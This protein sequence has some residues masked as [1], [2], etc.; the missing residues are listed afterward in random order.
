[1]KM[2]KLVVF[3]SVIVFAFS[4]LLGG[5]S[6]SDSVD[7]TKTQLYIGNF[8][9]GFGS[10]WLE[11]AKEYFEE[12]YK[13]VSFENGK[14]GVQI[15]IKNEKLDYMGRNLKGKVL[16]KEED[17][18]FAEEINYYEYFTANEML[19][20][21]DVVTSSMSEFNETGTIEDKLSKEQKEFLKYNGSYYALPHYSTFMG[22][23][24]DVKLFEEKGYYLDET[25]HC[26]DGEK[27]LGRDGVVS[28]D[29]GLPVTYEEFFELCE[30][31]LG[32]GNIPLSWSNHKGYLCSLLTSLY[33]AE[34]GYDQYMLNYTF[35][36]LATGL[37]A[38]EDEAG[39]K[40]KTETITSAN[41][42]LL[43]S[44]V[45]RL[46]ALEFY[47]S[48]IDG[49][50]YYDKSG[51]VNQG[52]GNNQLDYLKSGFSSG[53]KKIAMIIEGN[54]WENEAQINGLYDEVAVYGANAKRE[55][56]KFAFMPLPT[57]TE[58]QERVLVD[59]GRVYCFA[60]GRLANEPGKAEL[61]KMFIKY[62]YSDEQ[63][64]LF[65]SLSGGIKAVKYS[66][67]D[68]QINNLPTFAKSVWN[69]YKDS[70]V[71]YMVSG[72]KEFIDGYGEYTTLE[73][74]WSSILSGN[75][76]SRYPFEELKTETTA[77]EY[78]LGMDTNYNK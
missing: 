13:G 33:A 4:A 1:M 48:I 78:F 69:I 18:F 27:S 7:K 21:S 10:A 68:E 8:N 2:K 29:D 59:T 55:N 20:I 67:S 31:I 40:V 47:Q 72:S 12:T 3:L 24:Y 41:R 63:L 44:H 38:G 57:Y 51:G 22:I 61:A 74:L 16:S 49:L 73:N 75:T 46:R 26:T 5:C 53:T 37:Y 50:Y 17:I 54:W 14:K 56:R 66:M 64:Q 39:I 11:S 32:D 28:W 77:K 45:G 23:S 25:G 62:L 52:T 60:N 43:Y 6:N 58:K 34:Q 15:H 70:K 42:N 71:A 9:G 76:V 19:D 30:V 36:G 65:T 35:D